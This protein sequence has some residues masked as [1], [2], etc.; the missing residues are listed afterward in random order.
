MFYSIQ[1]GSK[2]FY[3]EKKKEVAVYPNEALDSEDE[4]LEDDD[5][6]DP[7]YVVD[8][9]EYIEMASESILVDDVKE[10][11]PP[12]SKKR[13]VV[14]KKVMTIADDTEEAVDVQKSRTDTW[15][16]QDIK[17]EPMSEYSHILPLCV[18]DPF[19]YFQC[20]FSN[21]LIEMIVYETNLYAIQQDR[22]FVTSYDEIQKFISILLH[23]GVVPLPSL[24]DYWATTTKVHQV[25]SLMSSK[26]FSLIRR[27]IHFNDNTKVKDSTDRFFKVRP[28]VESIRS[29]CLNVPET[30]RQSI[31]EVMVAYKGR[32]AGNLR[33]YI[34]KG[35]KVGIQIV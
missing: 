10:N 6:R 8:E 18:L 17:N 25:A 32:T 15:R 23:M 34:K 30:P 24:E 13:K 7:D 14:S 35:N 9:S 19:H 11:N 20:F 4:E 12:A 33:Q 22:N 5:V 31:D 2:L 1:L 28:L 3:G 26:R 16:K 27:T 21:E 29:A